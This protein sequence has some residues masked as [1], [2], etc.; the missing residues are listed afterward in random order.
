MQ[1]FHKRVTFGVFRAWRNLGVLPQGQVPSDEEFDSVND[2]VTPMLED[3]SAWNICFVPDLEA[4]EDEKFLALGHILADRKSSEFG[5]M[6]RSGLVR[7]HQ[8]R[9]A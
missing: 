4:I 3:L 5:A 7:V 6:G 8:Y 1:S 9:K 2:L